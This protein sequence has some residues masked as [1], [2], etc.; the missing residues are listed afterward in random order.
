MP[1][2]NNLTITKSHDTALQAFKNH[3]LILS[4]SLVAPQQCRLP[5]QDPPAMGLQL[6]ELIEQYSPY[7]E[8]PGSEFTWELVILRAQA[9][10]CLAESEMTGASLREHLTALKDRVYGDG[11]EYLDEGYTF[12]FVHEVGGAEEQRL[13]KWYKALLARI[14]Q[15]WQLATFEEEARRFHQPAESPSDERP[16]DPRTLHSGEPSDVTIAEMWEQALLR[17]AR[18]RKPAWIEELE[19]RGIQRVGDLM[20]E[21]ETSPDANNFEN[22]FLERVVFE[23]WD[24]LPP[25]N[26][27]WQVRGMEYSDITAALKERKGK[28]A[29]GGSGG[30]VVESRGSATAGLEAVCP[31][32]SAV[33]TT[34]ATTP[35]L[36][37]A[38][39]DREGE[40]RG[41]QQGTKKART[42]EASAVAMAAG[43]ASQPEVEA[44]QDGWGRATPKRKRGV[45]AVE[46]EREP[47][48]LKLGAE[49][50]AP[51]SMAYGTTAGVGGV[52]VHVRVRELEGQL[53][54]LARRVDGMDRGRGRGRRPRAR[55]GH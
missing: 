41:H 31:S 22:V 19:K 6:L 39:D 25:V 46:E 27:N 7:K 26:M 24:Y 42:E 2:K 16:F 5:S 15:Y 37:S 11:L 54:E 20:S 50:V 53:A 32:A 44:R 10:G 38:P 43:G 40:H 13:K 23:L 14:I 51:T 12:T 4:S 47:K 3:P 17:I 18:E 52:D 35:T 29:S 30:G 1:L 48:R 21:E 28:G 45:S 33:G 49:S 34:S 9:R 8:G 36:A 55:R